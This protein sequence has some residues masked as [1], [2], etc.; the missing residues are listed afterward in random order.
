MHYYQDLITKFDNSDEKTFWFGPT[1]TEQIEKLENVLGLKLPQDF[2]DFLVVCGG[3]G[4]AD[5]EICGIEDNDAT[6]DNG[7]TVNYS[8]TRCR[9]EFEL[10]SQ[11]AVIYLKDDEDTLC[12]GSRLSRTMASFCSGLQ[13]RRRS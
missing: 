11:Y 9:A 4:A 7:G 3:G 12:P 10:P 8:T 2:F 6:I 1:S 13:R 5:S